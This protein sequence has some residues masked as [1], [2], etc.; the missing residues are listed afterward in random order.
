MNETFYNFIKQRGNTMFVTMNRIDV[1]ENQQD[2]FAERFR[3][4]AGLV[5]GSPGFVRNMVL[6]PENPA[7]PHIVMT[8]WENRPAF[9]AW[10]KSDSFRQAHAK[11]G[12][13]SG[14]MFRGPSKLEMFESVTDSDT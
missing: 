8:F 4:R 12:Q 1:H 2:D 6:R 14:D 9:E 5:D 3:Q 7:D 11:A 13:A 10:T